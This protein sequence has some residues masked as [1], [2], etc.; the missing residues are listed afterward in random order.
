M[1]KAVIDCLPHGPG[2]RAAAHGV[3]FG[4]IGNDLLI[5]PRADARISIGRNVVGTPAG[6]DGAGKFP[7]VV[8][9]EGEI[10]GGVAFAAVRQRFRDIGAPVPFGTLRRIR[11]K[12]SIGTERP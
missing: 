9:R 12:A 1:A 8:G 2:C 4:E 6:G 11:R 7:A 10:A 3:T 5:A